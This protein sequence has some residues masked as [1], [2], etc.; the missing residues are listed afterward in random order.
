MKTKPWLTTIKPLAAILTVA[1][2]AACSANWDEFFI[3]L[4][5]LDAVCIHSFTTE[6]R[7]APNL[8]GQQIFYIPRFASPDPIPTGLRLNMTVTELS[9]RARPATT[10]APY[11]QLMA[12]DYSQARDARG[13]PIAGVYETR[14]KG[15]AVSDVRDALNQ[16]EI[17][18]STPF[19]AQ[20]RPGCRQRTFSPLPVPRPG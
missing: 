3:N 11:L 18:I 13:E 14:S 19:P 20:D 6:T 12:Q 10:R 8:Q 7:P 1:A 4:A 5:R 9:G 15:V 2:A 17:K 16:V